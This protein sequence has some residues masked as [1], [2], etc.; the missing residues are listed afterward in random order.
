[1]VEERAQS[2]LEE[3]DQDYYEAILRSRNPIVS[4]LYLVCFCAERDLLSQWR[5][6][7]GAG[8]RYCIQ[9]DPAG[10]TKLHGASPLLPVLYDR[11]EQRKLLNDVL[12]AHLNGIAGH[13]GYDPKFYDT[14][15]SCT[16]ACCMA[17]FALFKDWAFREEQEWR[18]V[19]LVR[20]EH[21][22]DKLDFWS[23]NGVV[24]PTLPLVRGEG[25]RLPITEIVCG[26]SAWPDQ[27]L[28]SAKLLATRFG[29]AGVPVVP[30]GVPLAGQLVFKQLTFAGR[31]CYAI[32]S[33]VA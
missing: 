20:P 27:A 29:Y 23:S 26:A 14:A 3:T 12:D 28:R 22:L 11:N 7:G 15:A 6:Y 17:A 32:V 8:S 24:K 2:P 18:C 30:S 10:F 33:V 1:V 19:L 9:F 4:D 5:G 25:E 13:S 31:A 16:Y 21:L